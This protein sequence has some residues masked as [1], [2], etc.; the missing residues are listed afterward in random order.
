MTALKPLRP[1]LAA[2][3]ACAIGMFLVPADRTAA[4]GPHAPV[5]SP[6]GEDLTFLAYILA[7]TEA[8]FAAWVAAD[9]SVASQN[10]FKRAAAA[11]ALE[12]KM[13]ARSDELKNV[14]LIH[15]D[16]R[17]RFGEYNDRYSE[18]DFNISDGTYID[19][20]T[21]LRRFGVRMHLVNGGLAETWSLPPAEAEKVVNLVGG[22]RN[23]VLGMTLQL[24][25]ATVPAE[26]YEPLSIDARVI[27]YDI[28]SDH[29]NLRLGHVVVK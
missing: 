17:S 25:A 24:V 3:L 4:A 9:R 12:T 8:P 2:M 28:V 26:D 23:V 15:I 29:K 11:K 14:R 27:E 1:W 6:T 16:L 19:F 13:R 22:D 20:Q 21:P 18:F 10:E 5:M 7:D